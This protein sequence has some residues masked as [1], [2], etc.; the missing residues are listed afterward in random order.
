[1]P[2][3]VTTGRVVVV[4]GR[5]VVV[6]VGGDVSGVVLGVTGDV[7][8]AEVGVDVGGTDVV[9]VVVVVT[10]GSVVSGPDSLVVAAALLPG[11]SL[12]TTNP[13]NA[14]APVAANTTARVIRLTRAWARCRVSGVC[15][16]CARAICCVSSF[17]PVRCGPA[18]SRGD[19]PPVTHVPTSL[20][21]RP[22]A[23]MTPVTSWEYVEY[24][25]KLDP[26]AR[27]MLTSC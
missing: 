11:C 1:V 16:L 7:L 5:V 21:I 15:L 18:V 9:V 25:D 23:N 17:R 19:R 6:V 26:R 20:R 22:Y 8:G 24:A 27:V 14:V 10:G 4:R 13:I 12:A 3:E 2:P